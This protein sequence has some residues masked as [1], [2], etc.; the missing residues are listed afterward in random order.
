MIQFIFGVLFLLQPVEI[1]TVQSFEGTIRLKQSSKYNTFYYDYY[2]KDQLVRVDKT[3]KSGQIMGSYIV[4]IHQLAVFA[5]DHKRNLYSRQFPTDMHL[6]KKDVEIIKS[7]NTK[8]VD[9]FTCYQWRV[10]NRKNNT[11]FAFWVSNE[12]PEFHYDVLG[13]LLKN[14]DKA[15][16][17]YSLIPD[18]Q[19]FMPLE[20]VE[21]NLV[22]KERFRSE[23]VTIHPKTLDKALFII[24]GNYQ[25]LEP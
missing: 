20:I 17:Y 2:I 5:I 8:E 16:F 18:K 10:R 15:H 7:Q 21:R 6:P 1:D 14:I 13:D 11:E 19:N 4:D 24:P 9:G 22:R 3:A 25:L 23:V 12:V